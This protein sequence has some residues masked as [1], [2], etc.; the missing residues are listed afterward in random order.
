MGI[1]PVPRHVST[2]NIWALIMW[3]PQENY[4]GTQ[5]VGSALSGHYPPHASLRQGKPSPL[6]LGLE[7]TPPVAIYPRSEAQL[8][9]PYP[10]KICRACTPRASPIISISF[11]FLIRSSLRLLFSFSQNLPIEAT[12]EVLNLCAAKHP[13]NVS[14]RCVALDMGRQQASEQI[15]IRLLPK[16]VRRMPSISQF[17][18]QTICNI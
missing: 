4:H 9:K 5:I 15:K 7:F 18:D 6:L 2:F 12:L 11:N 13:R 17:L 3:A 1:M 14:D 8:P 10:R 16:Q